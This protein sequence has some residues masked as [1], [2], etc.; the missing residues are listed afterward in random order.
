MTNAEN[1]AREL[2][3]QLSMENLLVQWELTTNC[4]DE[5]IP[6]VRGWLMDEFEKRNPEAFDEWLD[7]D[8][9]DETLRKY[10]TK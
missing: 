1:K 3:A 5:N 8:A 6:T 7:K 4:N 9:E 10:M 2:I